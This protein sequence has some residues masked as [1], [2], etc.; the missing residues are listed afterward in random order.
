[1]APADE[2]AKVRLSMA[3]V[4]GS[5]AIAAECREECRAAS[6]PSLIHAVWRSGTRAISAC[7]GMRKD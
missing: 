4:T 2:A 6:E 1:M 7:C 3:G 5:P